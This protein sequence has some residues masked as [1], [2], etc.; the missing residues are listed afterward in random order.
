MH[1]P[2]CS[3][4]VRFSVFT[5][6]FSLPEGERYHHVERSEAAAVHA[7]ADWFVVFWHHLEEADRDQHC[8]LHQKH[9]SPAHSERGTLGSEEQWSRKN[10]IVMMMMILWGSHGDEECT[11]KNPET[12]RHLLSSVPETAGVYFMTLVCWGPTGR[13]KKREATAW[14]RQS[15]WANFKRQKLE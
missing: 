13:D 15:R 8:D 14:W 4:S 10:T 9:P 7:A 6:D 11:N 5:C 3:T 2:T 1:K 12:R